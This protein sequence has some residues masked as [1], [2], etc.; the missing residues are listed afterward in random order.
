MPYVS[1]SEWESKLSKASPHATSLVAVNDEGGV[2]GHAALHISPALRRRHVADF[3]IAV[4]DD[5]Q[6]LGVGRQLTGAILDLA[7]NWLNLKRVALSVF[8]DN[9]TA[10]HLYKSFGFQ[11]EGES[12]F[13]AFR[14]G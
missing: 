4:R 14:D 11:V 5:Y 12:P 3:M 2:V 1:L 10:I 13:Y 6:G 8:T 9:E 7:D